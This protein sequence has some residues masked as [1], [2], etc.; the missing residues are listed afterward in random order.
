MKKGTIL[1]VAF[2][3]FMVMGNI[4]AQDSRIPGGDYKVPLGGEVRNG[5]LVFQSEDGEFLWWVD[6]RIQFDGAMYFENKNQLSNGT[7]LRRLTFAV[8]AQL[9]K[10]WQAELDLDFSEAVL[11]LRDMFIKYTVP[12]VNL[13]FQ[14]G[15][16]KEPFGME[17]LNSSRLLTFLERTAMSNAIPM[18]RRVGFAARYWED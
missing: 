7:Y 6:S 1:S 8:K 17:R 2:I 3:L 13:S 15:N 4:I 16:F 10:D 14:A 5:K 18:G 12:D 11:D 9:W